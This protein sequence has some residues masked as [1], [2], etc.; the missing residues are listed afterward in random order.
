[1]STLFIETGREVI[2]LLLNETRKTKVN[3]Y[4]GIPLSHN[5]LLNNNTV[6]I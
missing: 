6:K 4:K 5:C 2:I 3:S 1:M